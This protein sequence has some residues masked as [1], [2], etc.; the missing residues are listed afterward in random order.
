MGEHEKINDRKCFEMKEYEVVLWLTQLEYVKKVGGD[1]HKMENRKR[2]ENMKCYSKL[3]GKRKLEFVGLETSCESQKSHT[4]V[5][6]EKCSG[7]P[8]VKI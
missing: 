8:N 6:L 5:Y 3:L 2:R 7:Y 1:K 4:L